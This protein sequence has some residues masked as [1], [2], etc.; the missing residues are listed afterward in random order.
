[1]CA[2]WPPVHPACYAGRPRRI[3]IHTCSADLRFFVALCDPISSVASVERTG[4]PLFT[5]M[6]ASPRHYAGTAASSVLN[7]RG[8]STK[9]S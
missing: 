7:Q 5:A 6:V 8:R 9:I 4:L 3:L 2:A 1:M